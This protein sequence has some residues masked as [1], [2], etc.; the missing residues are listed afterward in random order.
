[1]AVVAACA[2]VA[3]GCGDD[4]NAEGNP[5]GGSGSGET[6][7]LVVSAGSSMTE[8]LEACAP[9]FEDAEGADVRMSFAGSDELAAQ[10]RQGAPVDVYAAADT[11]LPE[12][13]HGEGLLSEP[14]EFAT[15]ELV[16]AVPAG[17]EIDSVDDVAE[18]GTKVV[19]G[20]ESVPIGSYMRESLARL[21]PGQEEAILANVVSN[22]PDVKGILGKLTQGAGDA[23]FVYLTDVK[24]TGGELEAIDLPDELEP[25]V[26]Y[27]A[28]VPTEAHEP[29][30]GQAFVEG[31]TLGPCADALEAA[32]FGSSP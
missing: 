22:E 6:T 23:G 17:S 31:L 24:S 8:A 18:Q 2:A 15:N 1:V 19:A 30:L 12:E 21:P 13:L 25:R 16:L 29:E 26:T 32:G 11:R 3:A 27:G 9:D 20:S 28:G 10:I 5:G 4:D 7:R 14:V